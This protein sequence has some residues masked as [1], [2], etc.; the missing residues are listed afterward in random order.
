MPGGRAK[1]RGRF[2]SGVDH[3]DQFQPLAGLPGDPV[4]VLQQQPGHARADRSEPDNGD[5]GGVHDRNHS[6]S[7]SIEL[8]GESAMVGHQ[9]GRRQGGD[10]G[11]TAC[12]IRGVR[13]LNTLGAGLAMQTCNTAIAELV[14]NI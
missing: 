6:G 5:F 11:R 9:A 4:A 7:W 13:C 8:A 10:C 2:R 12:D 14:P 1:F 3:V